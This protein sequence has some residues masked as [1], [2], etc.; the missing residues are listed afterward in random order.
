M[1]ARTRASRMR[2]SSSGKLGTGTSNAEKPLP[3]I[4]GFGVRVPDGV[5]N[6]QVNGL[7]SVS[8]CR[9][10]HFGAFHF[11]PQ[12]RRSPERPWRVGHDPEEHTGVIDGRACLIGDAVTVAIRR[13]TSFR[14]GVTVRRSRRPDLPSFPKSRTA[15]HAGRFGWF[16]NPTWNNDRDAGLR[17]RDRGELTQDPDRPRD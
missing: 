12:V 14:D 3:G 9:E 11:R 1:P 17:H 6:L 4:S 13:R 15:A 2:R 10:V 7:R 5:P 16:R 8:V